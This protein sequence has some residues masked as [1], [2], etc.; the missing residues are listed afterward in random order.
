M[1]RRRRESKT[2]DTWNPR[3]ESL[4]KWWST[5]L[6]MMVHAALATLQSMKDKLWNA[7]AA[8]TSIMESATIQHHFVQRRSSSQSRDYKTTQALYSYVQHVSP[9]KKMWQQAR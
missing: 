5:R 4:S 6:T 2:D 8:N 1:E 3:E 9:L 7:L